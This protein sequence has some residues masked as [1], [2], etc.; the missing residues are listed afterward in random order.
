MTSAQIAS[1]LDI[2]DVQINYLFCEWLCNWLYK[3]GNPLPHLEFKNKP[4]KDLDVEYGLQGIKYQDSSIWKE[5]ALK[6]YPEEEIDDRRKD[7][8]AYLCKEYEQ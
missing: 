1:A 3:G 2:K 5:E 7:Q 6:V 4:P 8:L